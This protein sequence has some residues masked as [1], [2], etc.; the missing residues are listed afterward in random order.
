MA[1]RPRRRHDR[2]R[3]GLRHA[4]DREAGDA[5]RPPAAVTPPPTRD[6]PGARAGRRRDR[7]AAALVVGF[8]TACS[9]RS[10]SS[11]PARAAA[12]T[13]GAARDRRAPAAR[14]VRPRGGQPA[15]K[16]S[17]TVRS[18]LS[19]FGSRSA[20]DCHVPRAEL[21]A[22]TGTVTD[23]P[24]RSGSD[25][26]GAVA[27]RAVAVPP[28]VVARQE[29]V[30]GVE[31]VVVG[32]RAELEDHDARGRVRHEDREQPVAAVRLLGDEAPAG[33]GQVGEAALEPVRTD[34]RTWRTRRTVPGLG[35]DRSAGRPGAGRGRRPPAPTRSAPARRRRSPRR[36]RAAARR[37]SSSPG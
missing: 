19:A 3:R 2:P 25:V 21:A 11:C 6:R 27:G 22:D 24:A 17:R 18:A 26:V 12:A 30:E 5:V 35:E 28:A 9:R 23:G 1:A 34:S 29:P 4:R 10:C 13:D 8:A 32:P 36:P 33:A 16:H 7:H 37:R 31:G 15:R 14:R 20:I